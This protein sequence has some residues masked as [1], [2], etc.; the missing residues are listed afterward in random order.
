MR[1]GDAAPGFAAEEPG[2]AGMMRRKGLRFKH[3]N[4]GFCEQRSHCHEH[5]STKMLG[6][7]WGLTGFLKKHCDRP[8]AENNGSVAL[9]P[10]ACLPVCLFNLAD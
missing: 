9:W 3:I 1:A 7:V 6:R 8:R 5:T 4:H 10:F 2:S